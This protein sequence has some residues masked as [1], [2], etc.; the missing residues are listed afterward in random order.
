MVRAVAD[1]ERALLEKG[2]AVEVSH[3]RMYRKTIDGVT[4]LVTRVSHGSTEIGDTLAKL[5]ANQLCLQL[6]E[7][8]RLVDCPLSEGE[9]DAI[10]KQRCPDGRNP[11]LSR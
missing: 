8:W 7:F 10:V 9:W 4:Q 11:F 3:H 5:M 1:V 2:M 6:K